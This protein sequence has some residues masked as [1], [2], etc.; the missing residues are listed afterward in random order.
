MSSDPSE[1]TERVIGYGER[2]ERTGPG[3][4]EVFW[5]E[6]DHADTRRKA[7]DTIIELKAEIERL[8]GI[9]ELA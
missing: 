1:I 6:S 7:Y 5:R 8:R 4:R 3:G 9:R 2:V